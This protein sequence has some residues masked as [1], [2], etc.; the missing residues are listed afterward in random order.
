MPVLPD[1]HVVAAYPACCTCPHASAAPARQRMLP[2]LPRMLLLHAPAFMY[3]YCNIYNFQIKH[4]L[5][6]ENTCCNIRRKHMKHLKHTLTTY[7]WNICN[8]PIKTLANIRLK[9]MKHF[10]QT[11][12]TLATYATCAISQSTFINIH[13]KHLQHISKYLKHLKHTLA[14]CAFNVAQHLLAAWKNGGSLAYGIH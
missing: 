9:Q 2:C 8:I 3:N 5:Q 4:N 1:A 13:M 12:E 7:M 6:Y 14:T 11:L 10:E